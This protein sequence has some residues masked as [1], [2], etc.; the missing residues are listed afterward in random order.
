MKF[1]RIF[2]LEDSPDILGDVLDILD[3]HGFDK[4]SLFSRTVFAPDYQSGAEIVQKEDFELYILDAD[5]PEATSE[6]WKK[7]YWN[8]MQQVSIDTRHLDFDRYFKDRLGE[9][10]IGRSTNNFGPFFDQYLRE[11]TGKTI[12]YSISTIAPAVAFHYGLPFYS[13]ALEKDE[14]KGCVKESIDKKQIKKYIP[15]HLNP[16]TIDLLEEWECGS[17]FDLVQRYLL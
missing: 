12:I 10:Y 13:K 11:R 3:S 2:W 15:P 17:R 8:F 14:I 7:H 5:F 4:D 16:K 1:N 9:G 6:A